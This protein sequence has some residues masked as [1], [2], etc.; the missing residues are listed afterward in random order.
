M[1]ITIED[2]IDVSALT[3]NKQMANVLSLVD[4]FEFI[5]RIKTVRNSLGLRD[6]LRYEDV[7]KWVLDKKRTCNSISK[8]SKDYKKCF[9]L[10]TLLDI[11]TNT[12]TSEFNRN[13]NFK[14]IVKYAL[15]CGK[16]TNKEYKTSPY[17][18]IYPDHNNDDIE[19]DFPMVAILLNPETKF[20]EIRAIFKTK[21][22][23]LFKEIDSKRKLPKKEKPELLRDREWY[24]DYM[25][26][27]GYGYIEKKY[28]ETSREIVISAIKDYMKLLGCSCVPIRSKK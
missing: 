28:N 3:D 11:Q 10:L 27:G 5:K 19:L 17:C 24:W 22:Q 8:T 23:E 14:E 25:L 21:V 9:R 4:N 12:I 15:L 2:K 18:F 20:N 13:E 6:L 16:V 7:E 1:N 26:Y